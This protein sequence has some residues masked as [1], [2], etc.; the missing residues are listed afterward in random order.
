MLLANL[1][2]QQF[3]ILVEEAGLAKLDSDLS[4]G[5]THQ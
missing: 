3:M 5:A 1:F 4:G 2:R